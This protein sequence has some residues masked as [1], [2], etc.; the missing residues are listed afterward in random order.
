MEIRTPSLPPH[1]T[2]DIAAAAALRHWGRQTKDCMSG[3]VGGDCTPTGGM[4]SMSR[5]TCEAWGLAPHLG[6]TVA[7]LLNV[8]ECLGLWIETL[9]HSH[10]QQQYSSL[11]T[12]R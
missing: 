3:S 11:R 9:H 7:L 8:G 12:Q 10:C 4:I 6:G 1:T 2:A 5:V